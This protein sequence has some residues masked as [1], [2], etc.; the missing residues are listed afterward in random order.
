MSRLRFKFFTL[1]G[2]FWLLNRSEIG[3][4][5]Y[6]SEA[7]P[8]YVKESAPDSDTLASIH[9]ATFSFERRPVLY[10]NYELSE[11]HPTVLR[12]FSACCHDS[13]HSFSLL[14]HVVCCIIYD[15]YVAL[16]SSKNPFLELSKM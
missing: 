8:D 15:E 6:P 16:L 12:K 2:Y 3:G 1:T 9:K 4:N 14:K 7:D 5:R 10:G 11:S 13:T